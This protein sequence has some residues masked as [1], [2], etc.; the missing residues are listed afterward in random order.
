MSVYKRKYRNRK[1]GKIV[2]S[3]NW[4]ISYYFEGKKITESVSPNKRVA[5]DALKSVTGDIAKDKYRLRR[6]T[7][8][9]K[10]EDYAEVY[11]EYSK[12]NKRS[13]EADITMFK[14]LSA[15]FKGYKLSKMT[16][17]LIE[18]YKI[19]RG[20]KVA[21]MSKK[22]IA[23][24][25]INRELAI[26]KA[27]FSMAIRDGESDTNPVKAV[28]FFK[29]D[30][31]KERILT[32]EEIQR[33]L[34][35]CNGHI[36]PIVILALNTGMRLREVLYLKWSRIDF[37]RNIIIVTQTKSNKNRNIPMNGFVIKTIENIK[38]NSEYLFCD[39]KTGEPFDSIKTSFGKA[40]IRAGLVDVR[41][42]DLRH[43]AATMMVMSGV[44]LV[45]VKEI[46]GHSSIEMTMRYAHPTSEGKMNA[47]KALERQMEDTDSRNIVATA[48]VVSMPKAVNNSNN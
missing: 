35:E 41:F 15:F 6:D 28:K 12:A 2:E 22:P 21:R 44:D 40:L 9:P 17:F 48:K 31:Q 29:E 1:S 11:L 42:H 3:K 4:Y 43:T 8:S 45:T 14:A 46:L 38:R 16:P 37:N 34:A 33:L 13:Y 32:S 18:K 27:M 7:K 19:E 23:K 39:T 20:K 36:K 30:N 10:F 47:V 24:A 26:L 5:E 25:T